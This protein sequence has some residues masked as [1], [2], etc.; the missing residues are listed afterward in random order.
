M[1]NIINPHWL[2]KGLPL[3]HLGIAKIWDIIFLCPSCHFYL[4]IYQKPPI[5]RNNNISAQFHNAISILFKLVIHINVFDMV[6]LDKY[7]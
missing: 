2:S 6:K 7:K 4:S 3:F 5:F 1:L